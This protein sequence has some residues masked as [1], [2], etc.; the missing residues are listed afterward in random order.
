MNVFWGQVR[1]WAS[2][3]DTCTRCRGLGD[4]EGGAAPRGPFPTNTNFPTLSVHFKA[5]ASGPAGPRSEVGAAALRAGSG[6]GVGLAGVG[7]GR[8]GACGR[9]RVPVHF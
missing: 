5:A 3:C 7:E 2:L 1:P 4:R 9:E 6:E 8:V